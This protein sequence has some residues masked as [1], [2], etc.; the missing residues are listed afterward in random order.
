MLEFK[1]KSLRET[2]ALPS[3]KAQIHSA[4]PLPSATLGKEHTAKFWPAKRSL[5]SGF[6]RAL[7]KGF[8][9]CRHSAKKKNKKSR[10][11]RNFFFEKGCPSASTRQRTPPRFFSFF[12]TKSTNMPRAGLEPSSLLHHCTTPSVCDY[13]TFWF[14]IYHTKS[15]IN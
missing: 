8:A 9:E 13:I 1:A 3:V 5:P 12:S 4:K 2:G 11:N 14:L 6:Y 10:K 7:G 15:Y